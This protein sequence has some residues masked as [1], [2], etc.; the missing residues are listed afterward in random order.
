[1]LDDARLGCG[2]S[3]VDDEGLGFCNAANFCSMA[4]IL[5]SV[6]HMQAKRKKE[7]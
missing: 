6:L 1:M 3:V 5:A 2:V 4:K 7:V